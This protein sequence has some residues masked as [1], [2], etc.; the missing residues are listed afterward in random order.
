MDQAAFRV[1][2]DKQIYDKYYQDIEYLDFIG[3]TESFRSWETIKDLVNW[4]D[5]IVVDVGCFHGYFSF[6]IARMGAKV[7]G[8][9]IWPQVIETTSILNEVYGNLIELREWSAGT[10]VEG[11]FDVALFMNV[12]HHFKDPAKVI[13]KDIDCKFGVFEV[14]K[15]QLDMIEEHY[16]IEKQCQSH[17]PGRIILLGRKIHVREV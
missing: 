17:R 12:L 3:Y 15:D 9:D 5:K 14:N 10:L 13:S 2:L 4:K 7:T 1:H 6:K 8:L 16:T 11:H